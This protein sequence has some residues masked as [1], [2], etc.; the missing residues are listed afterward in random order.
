MR[1]N[2]RASALTGVLFFGN[3]L[4]GPCQMIFELVKKILLSDLFS[5]GRQYG[6]EE[7]SQP[8]LFIFV[9]FAFQNIVGNQNIFYCQNI[10]HCHHPIRIVELLGVACLGWVEEKSPRQRGLLHAQK[11]VFFIIL[12]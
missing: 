12:T 10:F 6:F 11:L 9:C 1:K 2:I 3:Y 7:T 5:N 8:N 4:L